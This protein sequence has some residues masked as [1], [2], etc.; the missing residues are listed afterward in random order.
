MEV[1]YLIF[2]DNKLSVYLRRSYC[3]PN[4][5]VGFGSCYLRSVLGVF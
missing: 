3:N 4:R 1:M 2:T 5:T